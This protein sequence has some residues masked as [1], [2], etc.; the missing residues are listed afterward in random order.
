MESSAEL[1]NILAERLIGGVVFVSILM[2]IGCAGNIV[3]LLVYTFRMKASNHRIFIVFLGLLDFLA[4]SVAMPFTVITLRQPEMFTKTPTCK[5]YWFANYFICSASGLA[6]LVIAIERY[7]KICVPLGWQMT[8][9]TA[10]LSCLVILLVTTGTSWPVLILMGKTTVPESTPR[11]TDSICATENKENYDMYQIYYHAVLSLLVCPCF[12]ALVVLYGL[13]WRVVRKYNASKKDKYKFIVAD[14]SSESDRKSSKGSLNTN[15]CNDTADSQSMTSSFM[16]QNSV[17]SQTA[18]IN[19][20]K[21][22]KRIKKTT[23]AFLLITVIF[24]ISYIPYLILT[25]LIYSNAI[26]VLT[27]SGVVF[28]NI[29]RFTPYINNIANVFIYGCFDVQFRREVK[30]LYNTCCKMLRLSQT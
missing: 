16:K 11:I 8:R 5:L 20:R 24:F 21:K 14:G 25:I 18:E 15:K 23:I 6:L 7:R 12:V 28:V 1:Y 22:F 26:S 3:V 19:D 2:V 29:I 9:R 13:V 10:I 17:T 4:S 27:S 30:A